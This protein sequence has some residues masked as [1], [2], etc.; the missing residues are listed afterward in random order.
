M[1][2]HPQSTT[3]R[4]VFK[5]FSSTDHVTAATG[6]TIAVQLSKN[7]GAFANPSAGATNATQIASG[8]YY[9]DLS[10]SDTDTLGPL[11]VRGTEGTIDPAETV[12]VIAKATNAGFSALPDAAAEAAGGLFTRGSGPGQINQESDGQIDANVAAVNTVPVTGAGTSSEPWGPG[13]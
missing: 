11:I 6:K 7:G 9:V 13:A 5:A 1:E 12:M 8:W 3:K 4:V 2:R 10:V